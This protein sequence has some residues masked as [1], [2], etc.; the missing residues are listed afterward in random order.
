[1]T[2]RQDLPD[3]RLG[4]HLQVRVLRLSP[5]SDLPESA[6]FALFRT[7]TWLSIAEPEDKRPFNFPRIE[8]P[9]F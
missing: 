6:T 1:M 9:F 8:M 4:L 5:I 2:P 3:L 7:S